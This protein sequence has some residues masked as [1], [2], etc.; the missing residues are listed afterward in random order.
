MLL[1]GNINMKILINTSNLSIGGGMQVALSFINEL[2]NLKLDNEYHIFLSVALKNQINQT[3]FLSNFYFYC[4]EK[5]PSSLRTRKQIVSQLDALENDINPDIVL[6]VFTPTYWRPKSTHIV[7]F[8]L[9]WMIN[10]HSEAYRVLGL[11]QKIRRKLDS[12]Y[13]TYYVKRDADYYIVETEDV[14]EKLF[15]VLNIV[16]EKTFVVGN[17]YS[18]EFDQDNYAELSLPERSNHEFRLVTIAHN[19]PHKNIKIIKEVLPYLKDSALNYKFFITI[20]DEN[21][22]TIFKGLEDRV[23]NLGSVESKY[24]PSLYDQCDALFLPTLLESFTAS[25]PEAMKM[26]KPILTSDLSFAH[27][28]CQDAAFYFDP[29]DPKDIANKII[30]LSEDQQLQN[31]LIIKGTER[32]KD[33]ETAESRARKYLS[34][35]EK[36]IKKDIH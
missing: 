28:L 23:I 14:K 30:E 26:K 18:S 25:Y 12:M 22:R 11:K 33:F 2:N 4:I 6:S 15:K 34:I 16:K 7:G 9:G 24:C 20:D 17:T 29:L 13:K 5:S 27:T 32:L 21:Y 8:A 31:E 36:I 10:P 19:Y 3:F 35:C 1:K